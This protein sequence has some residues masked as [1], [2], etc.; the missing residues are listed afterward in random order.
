LNRQV[1][2]VVEKDFSMIFCFHS[3]PV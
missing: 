3:S 2:E 1:G